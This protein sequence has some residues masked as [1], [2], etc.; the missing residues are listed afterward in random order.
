MGCKTL[1]FYNRLRQYAVDKD[2]EAFK[3][4]LT[5]GILLGECTLFKRGEVVFVVDT[6]ILSGLVKVRRKGR[7]EEYWTGF[8]TIKSNLEFEVSEARAEPGRCG[9]LRCRS[10]KPSPS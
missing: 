4:G 5:A 7:L 9:E 2:L 3:Q 10:Q 6:K 1:E 8:E